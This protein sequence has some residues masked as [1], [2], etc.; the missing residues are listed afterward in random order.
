MLKELLVYN[1]LS[2]VIEI[3]AIKDH[4]AGYKWLIYA[5]LLVNDSKVLNFCWLLRELSF[6]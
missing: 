6:Y 4:A 3:V 1:E 5:L 2:I